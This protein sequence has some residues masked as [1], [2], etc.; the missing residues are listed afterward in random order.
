MEFLK[1]NIGKII[2]IL[3][4][5]SYYSYDKYDK[6]KF[7]SSICNDYLKTMDKLCLENPTSY[8]YQ[9]VDKITKEKLDQYIKNVKEIKGHVDNLKYNTNINTRDYIPISA[10]EISNLFLRKNF[11][12]KIMIFSSLPESYI[13]MEPNCNIFRKKYGLCLKQKSIDDDSE[14]VFN[15]QFISISNI[16]DFPKI[17]KIIDDFSSY[18]FDRYQLIAYGKLINT[19]SFLDKKIKAD[20]LI[21]K[22]VNTKKQEY[23]TILNQQIHYSEIVKFKKFIKKK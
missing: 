12:E 15:N 2:I 19:D 23:E 22:N 4:I 11:D 16:N 13:F 20:H 14:N 1:N 10:Y 6:F 9:L 21:I 18:G 5:I 7:N 17:K 8:R 3:A